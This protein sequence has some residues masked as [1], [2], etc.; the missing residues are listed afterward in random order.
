MEK[1]QVSQPRL[2]PAP[3]GQENCGDRFCITLLL[4]KVHKGGYSE[5]KIILSEV[6]KKNSTGFGVLI[7]LALP[8]AKETGKWE[9]AGGRSTRLEFLC[10]VRFQLLSPCVAQER[11]KHL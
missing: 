2:L 9:A 7:P 5:I 11:E 4:Q 10:A 1:V 3:V 6:Q 8:S